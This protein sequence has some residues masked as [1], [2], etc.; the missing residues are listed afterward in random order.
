MA[1]HLL[2]WL[3]EAS[4][5]PT[6]G[7][8]ATMECGETWRGGQGAAFQDIQG[9][10]IVRVST[11]G[12]SAVGSAPRSGRGGRWFKSSRPDQPY[13]LRSGLSSY[14]SLPAS[15]VGHLWLGPRPTISSHRF[16]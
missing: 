9:T 5:C 4:G 13:Q 2:R 14:P 8:G 16:I 7:D 11:S 1:A 12:R 3:G 10:V 6:P 15:K